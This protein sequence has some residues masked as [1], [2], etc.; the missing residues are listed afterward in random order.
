MSGFG[1]KLKDTAN[2]AKDAAVE[3]VKDSFNDDKKSDNKNKKEA[4]NEKSKK[5]DKDKKKNKK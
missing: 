5:E 1:D 4:K 3:E 2:R